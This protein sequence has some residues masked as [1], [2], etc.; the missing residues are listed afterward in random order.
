M[1]VAQLQEETKK[2]N[3]QLAAYKEKLTAYVLAADETRTHL[4]IYLGSQSDL[5]T[6]GTTEMFADFPKFSEKVERK[7]YFI[8]PI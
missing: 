3:D 7:I 1:E 4:K 2:G 8:F 6:F 5:Q